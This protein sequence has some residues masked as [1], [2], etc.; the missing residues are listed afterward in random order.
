MSPAFERWLRRGA[1]AMSVAI[2]AS[3]VATA[4]IVVWPRVSRTVGLKPAPPPPAYRVGQTIDT[5]REWAQAT[6][7]TLVLFAQSSCGACQKAEPFFKDLFADLKGKAA[8]VLTSHGPQ[9]ADELAYGRALGLDDEAIKE[10]PKGLRVK[11]TPTLVLVDRNGRILDT[12]EG[13]GPASQQ[14]QIREKILSAIN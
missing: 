5:P 14:K 1:L 9:R 4:T 7:V 2:A 3:F 11:A 10:T 6:P 12:W 8:V 13:V